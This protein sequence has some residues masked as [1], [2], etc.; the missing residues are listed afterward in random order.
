MRIQSETIGSTEL[1]L[2]IDDVHANK[3]WLVLDN[4]YA[5]IG[6]DLDFENIT[7]LID[8]LV[9]IRGKMKEVDAV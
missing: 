6:I 7:K 1:D 3:V 2:F 4:K 8:A 9:S 5:S